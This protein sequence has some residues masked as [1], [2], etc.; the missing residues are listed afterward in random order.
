MTCLTRAI[1]APLAVVL[2]VAGAG[3]RA[4][5]GPVPKPP[6]PDPLARA[7]LG[8]QVA[9]AP[10]GEDAVMVEGVDHESP[11]DRAGVR[12]G[13]RVRSLAGCEVDGTDGLLAVVG[14]LRPGAVVNLVVERDGQDRT[15][16]VTL[17]VVPDPAGRDHPPWP[18]RCGP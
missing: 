13:D 1:V 4:A 12:T 17:G 5:A 10:L 11:A 3:D 8:L 2:L 14:T 15:L 16:R 6:P 9:S 7:W 18:T